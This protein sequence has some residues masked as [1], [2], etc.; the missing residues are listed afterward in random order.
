MPDAWLMLLSD[1]HRLEP[2]EILVTTTTDPSWTSY[3]SIAGAVVVE[4][5]SLLSHGAV[6]A[7]EIGIPAVV[8]LPGIVAALRDGE[9]LVVDG[10]AGTVEIY[11]GEGTH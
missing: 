3:F 2:G 8:G 7:R 6:V 5:G 1:A 4:I 10:S 11:S 9:T